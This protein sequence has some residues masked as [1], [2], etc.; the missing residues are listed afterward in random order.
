VEQ[1]FRD[2]L[3]CSVLAHGFARLR[4]QLLAPDLPGGGRLDREQ[5]GTMRTTCGSGSHVSG[6]LA[7]ISG[8]ASSD[9]SGVHFYFT[10]SNIA[11]TAL[12]F[13]WFFHAK[14]TS[15]LNGTWRFTRNDG[16]TNNGTFTFLAVC[17]GAAMETAGPA[18]ND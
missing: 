10:G 6:N 8:S 13:S 1:E 18:A 16:F 11:D 5:E 15:G 17:P 7:A 9:A 12:A 2:F 4:G 14:I 3:T